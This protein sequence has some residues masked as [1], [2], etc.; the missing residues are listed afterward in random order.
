MNVFF[1]TYGCTLNQADAELAQQLV[2]SHGHCIVEN[3]KNADLVI[4]TTCGV[5]E[6]TENK[7]LHY[8]QTL[9]TRKKPYIVAGCLPAMN[10]KKVKRF[11]PSA[12]GF[13]GPNHLKKIPEIMES[14]NGKAVEALNAPFSEKFEISPRGLTP[15]TRIQISSGCLS[16]CSFCGT[17]LA[18]GMFQSKPEERIIQEAERAVSA[19]AKELQ[20]CSQDTGCYGFDQQTNLARVVKQLNALEG[21]FRIRIGMGSPHHMMRFEDELVEALRM[22]HTYQFLHIPL[23]SGNNEILQAMR[24]NYAVEDVQGFISRSRKAIP[25]ITLATDM[26][27]GFPGESEVQHRDS[28]TLL[29]ELRFDVVNV[30]KYSVREGTKAAEMEQVPSQIKK[31]RAKGMAVQERNTAWEKNQA[32]IGRTYPVL[33]T[34][35]GTRGFL[36]GRNDFYKTVLVP[37]EGKEIGQFVEAEI[38]SATPSYLKA[39]K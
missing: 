12:N 30:S 38:E 7:I 15:I 31:R 36:A 18:R 9:E 37:K 25:G 33:L 32:F 11:A 8:L 16:A 13:I 10:I 35:N 24:R 27:V 4:A 6:T 22:P 26:I 1:K 39:R 21:R 2:Q 23:Q 29:K 34:E 17:K 3:E 14:L 20:L 19:G 28:M 5:K